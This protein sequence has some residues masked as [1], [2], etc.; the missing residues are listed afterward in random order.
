[1]FYFDYITKEG[2]KK[3]NPNWLAIPDHPYLIL[4]IGDCRSDKTNAFCDLIIHEPDI[5]KIFLYVKDSCEAKYQ[6]LIKRA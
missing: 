1:M 4:I 6:L 5:D 2:I 3:H